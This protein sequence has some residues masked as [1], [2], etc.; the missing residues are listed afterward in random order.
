MSDPE[1]QLPRRAV[2][3]RVQTETPES[4]VTINVV[5]RR[6]TM[7]RLFDTEL[8]RLG[9]AQNSIHLAFFTLCI[10]IAFG[11]GVTL[12]TV[13]IT[14]PKKFAAFVALFV[15]SVLAS[16]YFGVMFRRD[17]KNSKEELNRIKQGDKI[18]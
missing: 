3:R 18:E 10:G 5:P 4:P 9:S 16:L 13:D 1:N 15:V 17:Y 12:L 11:F 7:Y 14:D 8:E 2:F 6:A